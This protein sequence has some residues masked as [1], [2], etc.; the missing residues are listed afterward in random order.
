MAR[1]VKL[2]AISTLRLGSSAGKNLDD[3]V[4]DAI[5]A[6]EDMLGNVICEKPDLIALPEQID[7]WPDLPGERRMEYYTRRGDRVLDFLSD[8]AARH[9]VNLAYNCGK[10]LPDGSARNRTV[11]LA[12]NGGVDGVYDKNHLVIEENTQYGML[13][14][15]EAPVI[16]TDFGTAAGITCFDLNFAELREKYEA[17]RPELLVFCSQYH[18]SD[19]VQSWWA[20]SCRSWFLSAVFENE[21]A[22]VD[23]LGTKVAHS[24]NYYPWFVGEANLDYAVLHLDHNW[25]KIFEARKKYGPEVRFSDP[26]NLGA[27]LLTSESERFT[28]ADI[29][30]EF[31]IELVDDYFRRS[32]AHRH[33]PGHM[34]GKEAP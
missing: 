33:A 3:C 14:G 4:S 5:G 29:V 30:K 1:H 27:V 25:E 31:G 13:Y 34:A 8:Y 16:R 21:C 12:R 11:F 15:S 18:G 2:A 28:A 7:R 23:P 9:G 22:L 32:L 10:V 20:W 6:L 19:F 26:G 17:S 24:T